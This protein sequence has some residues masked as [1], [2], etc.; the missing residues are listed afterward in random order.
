MSLAAK[1]FL[2]EL[3]RG[4][5]DILRSQRGGADVVEHDHIEAAV[6]HRTV[7]PHILD[8]RATAEA[9][10]VEALH[11]YLDG[12]ERVELDGLAVLEHLE[13]VARQAPDEVSLLVGDDDIDVDVVDL[14]LKCDGRT[15]R[16]SRGLRPRTGDAG[17]TNNESKPCGDTNTLVIPEM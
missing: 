2:D 10:R 3:A 1:C 7:G 8:D 5:D 11:R 6:E 15:L 4:P 16:I 14:D 17:G 13:V 12:R 9:R